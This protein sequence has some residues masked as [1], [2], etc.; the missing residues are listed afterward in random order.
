[1][2]ATLKSTAL[3]STLLVAAPISLSASAQ[4]STSQ[5]AYGPDN[6]RPGSARAELR[7]LMQEHQGELMPE[8]RGAL[9]AALARA[10]GSIL[11]VLRAQSD[12][13]QVYQD[14]NWERARIYDGAG[15]AVSLAYMEDLWRVA[16]HLPTN[17][18]RANGDTPDQIKQTAVAFALYNLA[19]IRLDGARCADST[20]PAHRLD[21]LAQTTGPIIAYG[22]TL[23]AAERGRVVTVAVNVERA[24]APARKDDPLL[25]RGGLAEIQSGLAANGDK[26]LPRSKEP[27]YVGSVARVPDAP[28]YK[29]AFVPPDVWVSKQQRIRLPLRAELE[30]I[31]TPK[32]SSEP[33]PK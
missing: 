23:S 9:D 15:L 29:P 20:A 6:P 28:G 3:I 26:S 19:L 13:G 14:L 27:G 22:R 5:A 7:A 30:G 8:N 4:S 24:S 1:M 32:A 11:T 16:P 12:A 10:D 21:Q 33:T 18:T 17:S 31:I 2:R 25:C